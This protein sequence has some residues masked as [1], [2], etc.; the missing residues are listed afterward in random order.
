MKKFKE[1]NDRKR[2]KYAKL[3]ATTDFLDLGDSYL[4]LNLKQKICVR[5]A[6]HYLS[7]WPE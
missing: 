6:S 1:I 4:K 2:E 5:I 3:D 7:F